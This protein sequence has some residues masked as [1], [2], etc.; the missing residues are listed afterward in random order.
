[1]TNKPIVDEKIYKY[2]LKKKGAVSKK[3]IDV[4]VDA[5]GMYHMQEALKVDEDRSI[6]DFTF[7]AGDL[8]KVIDEVPVGHAANLKEKVSLSEPIILTKKGDSDRE[9]KW[10]FKLYQDECIKKMDEQILKAV[11]LMKEEHMKMV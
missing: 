8:E 9:M 5:N 4:T 1:M 3:L 10:K 11:E 2:C 7:T 6:D